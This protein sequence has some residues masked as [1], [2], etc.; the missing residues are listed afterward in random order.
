VRSHLA[1]SH[2][3]RPRRD[4]SWDGC[5]SVPPVSWSPSSVSREA[6]ANF[7][8]NRTTPEFE[9]LN[10]AAGL[11]HQELASA[12]LVAASPQSLAQGLISHFWY[13]SSGA[14]ASRNSSGAR[15]VELL[16]RPCGDRMEIPSDCQ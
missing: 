15:Q 16:W 3:V 14:Q 6:R 12:I 1:G 10:P 11:D 8:H 7:D 5:S 13:G 9:G 2:R 4:R